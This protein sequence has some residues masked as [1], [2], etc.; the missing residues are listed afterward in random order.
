MSHLSNK[1]KHLLDTG[2]DFATKYNYEKRSLADVTIYYNGSF[3][4]TDTETKNESDKGRMYQC[5]HWLYH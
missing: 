1:R 4:L 3:T 5:G 2:Q